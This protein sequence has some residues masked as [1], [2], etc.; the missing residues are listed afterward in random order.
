[1]IKKILAKL[2]NFTE[3]KEDF[4]KSAFRAAQ[5]DEENKQFQAKKKSLARA[6]QPLRKRRN[7]F[8]D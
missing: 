2:M 1:M 4:A 7:K 3:Q 8:F 6:T 5:K